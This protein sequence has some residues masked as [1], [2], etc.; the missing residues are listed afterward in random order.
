MSLKLGNKVTDQEDLTIGHNLDTLLIRSIDKIL[1]RNTIDRLSL[2][3]LEILGK[4]E[5]EAVSGMIIKTVK[6]GLES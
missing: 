6:S 1:S 5:P 2:K 3:S 4:I